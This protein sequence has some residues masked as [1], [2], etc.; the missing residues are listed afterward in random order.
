MT[1]R[2]IFLA[3]LPAAGALALGVKQA[4]AAAV[5][6]VT[7]TDPAAAALGYKADATK[8]DIKKFPN[9]VKGRQCAGCQ[10]YA[11]KPADAAAPCGVFGGK[12]VAG[13]GWCAAWAKKA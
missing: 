3:S 5:A 9:Y 11:G 4:S 8:V 10:L 1:S 13:K 12:L 2:R 7:E 6:N